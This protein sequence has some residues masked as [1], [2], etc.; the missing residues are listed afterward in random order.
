MFEII[1]N[2]GNYIR[3]SDKLLNKIIAIFVIL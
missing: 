2:L 1:S 3:N